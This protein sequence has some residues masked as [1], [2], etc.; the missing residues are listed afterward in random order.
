MPRFKPM[1][2]GKSIA[3]LW[4]TWSGGIAGID[5]VFPMITSPKDPKRRSNEIEN[6]RSPS[7]R[8]PVVHRRASEP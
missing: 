7:P 8:T 6:E 4:K 5:T 1:L 2:A 3:F